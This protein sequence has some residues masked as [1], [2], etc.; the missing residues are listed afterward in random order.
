MQSKQVASLHDKGPQLVVASLVALDLIEDRGHLAR[1]KHRQSH[2]L[3][4]NLNVG[5]VMDEVLSWQQ[6]FHQQPG[7]R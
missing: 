1:T 7:D 6:V 3:A 2:S 4:F 5:W